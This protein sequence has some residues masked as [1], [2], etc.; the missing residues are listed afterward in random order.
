MIQDWPVV[1]SHSPSRHLQGP[2]IALASYVH[3]YCLRSFA[4][5]VEIG[6]DWIN[7]GA[8]FLREGSKNG[9]TAT[10]MQKGSSDDGPA[11]VALQSGDHGHFISPLTPG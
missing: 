6:Q 9:L 5:D 10:E 8:I 1:R 2:V 3:R 4:G 11:I 7:A